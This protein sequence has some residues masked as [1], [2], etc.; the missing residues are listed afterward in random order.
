M[1]G[2]YKA[3][4]GGKGPTKSYT[5]QWMLISGIGGIGD[6]SDR[7]FGASGRQR[8]QGHSDQ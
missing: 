8:S 6:R 7:E 4:D 2:F 5:L 1:A 3:L